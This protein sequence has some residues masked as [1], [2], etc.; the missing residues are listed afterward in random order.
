[1][2]T[3]HTAQALHSADARLAALDDEAAAAISEADMAAAM[4]AALATP[5]AR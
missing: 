2:S 3:T 5:P 1:M 4:A